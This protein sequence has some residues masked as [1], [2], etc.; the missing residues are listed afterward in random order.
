MNDMAKYDI[1]K[2]YLIFYLCLIILGAFLMFCRWMNHIDPSITILP[3]FL[4]NHVTNFSLCLM[5]L[6][7]IGFIILMFGGNIKNVT[8]VALAV[9]FLNVIYEVFLPMLNTPDI[10]DALSGIC[11][12]AAAYVFLTVLKKN[13]LTVK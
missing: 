12:T 13:G 1:K 11:G 8:V 9:A 5:L 10:I 7:I 4:L 2:R 3:A 6:L